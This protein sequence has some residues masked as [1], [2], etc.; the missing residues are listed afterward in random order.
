[1]LVSIYNFHWSR[2]LEWQVIMHTRLVY[3][4]FKT[5]LKVFKNGGDDEE[6]QVLLARGY[7][8]KVRSNWGNIL[9]RESS[10]IL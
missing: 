4:L 10:Y 8:V 5:S 9:Q 6:A 2:L 1:M 3:K 7:Y